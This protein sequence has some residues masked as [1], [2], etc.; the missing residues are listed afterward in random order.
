MAV[1]SILLPFHIFY[2][3]LV[4]L[5]SFWYIFSRFGMVYQENSGNPVPEVVFEQELKLVKE[6]TWLR[7]LSKGS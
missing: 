4:C 3:H 2:G 6:M 5:W 7:K 1:W